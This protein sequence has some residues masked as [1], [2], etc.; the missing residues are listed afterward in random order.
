MAQSTTARSG[1]RLLSL[2]VFRGATVAGMMM[3]NNPGSWSFIY[4]PFK[5]AEWNGWTFTDLIFPFFLWIVGVAMTY[6]FSKRI[7]QGADRNKLMIHT[8]QRAMTIF[9]IGLFLNGFPFGLL[10]GHQFSWATIRIPGVLQRIAICY[11]IAGSIV[12]YTSRLWQVRWTMIFLVVY[13]ILIKSV[14]VPEF[15]AGAIEHAKGSLAWY[16]DSILLSGH[17]WAG[18]PA[19]GFDPEGIFSTL[20]AIATTLFGV[21]TGH[22]IRSDRTPEE[23]TGWMFVAGN[24]LIFIGAVMDYWLPINKNLWTSTYSIFMA[25]MALDIFAFCYWVIDVKGHTRWAKPFQIYGMNAITMFALAGLIGRLTAQIKWSG[26]DGTL[27]TLKTWYYQTFFVW[28]GDP[29]FASFLHSVAFMLGLY[30]I[31]WVMYKYNIII[32]V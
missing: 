11:L 12:L 2:D 32:K 6:S 24:T 26:A 15:G 23:K 31:A 7:E 9:A 25:G 30:V 13:W 4:P 19:P 17:T 18:A 29:M 21:L 1:G 28:I 3:V 16:L 27:I 14:P 22:F 5:H 20:P 8:L 10:F